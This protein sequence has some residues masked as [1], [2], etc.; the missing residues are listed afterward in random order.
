MWYI[1]LHKA[2]TTAPVSAK[3]QDTMLDSATFKCGKSGWEEEEKK[4]GT[5]CGT[6]RNKQL[7]LSVWKKKENETDRRWEQKT[8]KDQ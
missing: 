4:N 7:R 8:E 1:A 3:R 2:A 5:K 6:D